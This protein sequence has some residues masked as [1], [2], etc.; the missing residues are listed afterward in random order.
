M[1]FDTQSIILWDTNGGMGGQL[2]I[3]PRGHQKSTIVEVNLTFIG[4]EKTD[5]WLGRVRDELADIF[6][7]DFAKFKLPKTKRK[8]K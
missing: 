6:A 1:E 7:K 8:P 4:L 5:F 3:H 2:K